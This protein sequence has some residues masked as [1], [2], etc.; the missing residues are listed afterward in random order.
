MHLSHR[1]SK[2]YTFSSK[3]VF[4]VIALCLLVQCVFYSVNSY[5]SET[6]E[7]PENINECV[8]L[9]HGLARTNNS[10]NL[11]ADALADDGYSVVNIGYPSRKQ[12]I[13]ALAPSHIPVA[14]NECRM[15]GSQ[16]I[17]FVTHSMG[18]ILVRYYLS[19]QRFEELGRVVMLSPPNQG[20]EVV[21]KLA[22]MPGFELFNGPAGQQLGTGDGSVP[23]S[24]GPV[25]YPVGVIT[26]N[27]SIN[28]FLSLLIPG[29]DDGKVSI[30]RAKVE[31]MLDF[32]VVPHTHPMIMRS[33]NVIAQTKYFI[34]SGEFLR[35]EDE[36]K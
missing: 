25:D 14:L 22:D 35:E 31:G 36:K 18:G 30:E 10:M 4:G 15:L 19:K 21:D 11:M 1:Q 34:K 27:K 9:L 5:A 23:N 29:D 17:H 16:R 28:L 8:V 20:S 13:E 6:N 32:L 7:E 2:L 24:L 12:P 33:K 3:Y 26:G